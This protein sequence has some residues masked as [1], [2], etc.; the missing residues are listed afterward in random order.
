MSVRH[1]L[2][3]LLYEGPKYGLQL[4]QEFEAGTGEVWP[5]NDGQV[6][7]TLQRLDRAGLVA[8]EERDGPQRAYGLTEDGAAE[9][10][11]WLQTPPEMSSPPRDELVIKILIAMRMADV[12]VRELVQV[13]RRK[14]VELMQQ[15]T[16]LKEDATDDEIGLSLAVDAELFR[17]DGLVRW[18]DAVDGR[19]KRLTNALP[20]APPRIRSGP[21]RL[22]RRKVRP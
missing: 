21:E 20:V 22:Q 14:L 15:Y 6:Y 17:L 3:A 1:A 5:L 13:H 11:E 8:S 9:L 4:Q 19:L 12:D 10:T 7:A 18:L 2:L 16:R